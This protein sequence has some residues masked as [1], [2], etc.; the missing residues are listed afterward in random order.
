MS[1]GC[2]S[3]PS[4]HQPQSL[5]VVQ[6]VLSPHRPSNLYITKPWAVCAAGAVLS[7]CKD[8][9]QLN[10]GSAGTPLLI[11]CPA[12]T[13]LLLAWL[14]PQHPYPV[15]QC[16]KGEPPTQTRVEA[17]NQNSTSIFQSPPCCQ[18]LFQHL[19]SAASNFNTPHVWVHGM[20]GELENRL[21]SE[22]ESLSSPLK[23][24]GK[25]AVTKKQLWSPPLLLQSKA[26][27]KQ[28]IF[29]F[30][31][32]SIFLPYRIITSMMTKSVRANAP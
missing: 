12:Q 21:L 4:L 20:H 32:A 23:T 7:E 10:G 11:A 26:R 14:A 18:N 1:Q 13:Q 5:A 24:S 28:S 31:G 29:V 19:P 22:S 15:G 25:G 8:S 3:Q 9:L 30:L 17:K 6:D 27:I 16:L 2:R